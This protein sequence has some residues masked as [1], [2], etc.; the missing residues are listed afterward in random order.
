MAHKSGRELRK[1]S[2]RALGD[3]GSVR[4]H[5]LF[6]KEAVAARVVDVSPGGMGVM[7]REFLPTRL[8]RVGDPVDIVHRKGTREEA[9]V[10]AFVRNTNFSHLGDVVV[11]RIGLSFGACGWGDE[12]AAPRE[13][14]G[15]PYPNSGQADAT[16]LAELQRA[17]RADLEAAEALAA[18]AAAAAEPLRCPAFFLPT[19]FAE[20]PFFFQERIHFQVTGF[21]PRGLRLVCSARNKALVPG[22]SLRMTV[23][24]PL[25]GTFVARARPG[26]ARKLAQEDRYEVDAV[27]V[28]DGDAQ[29]VMLGVARYLLASGAAPSVDALEERGFPVS[30]LERFLQFQIAQTPEEKE[31]V[32][33]YWRGLQEDPRGRLV[34]CRLGADILGAGQ[35]AFVKGNGPRSVIESRVA[36]LATEVRAEGYVE[37]SWHCGSRNRHIPDAF[38]HFVKNFARLTLEAG[39]RRMITTCR[40]ET[41]PV[42]LALG[43]EHLQAESLPEWPDKEGTHVLS[44]DVA[45]VVQGRKRI[46]RHIWTKVYE[47]VAVHVG[48]LGIPFGDGGPRG[49][50]KAS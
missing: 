24:L 18:A 50:K 15:E 26:V 16:P 35:I 48:L 37:V 6:G 47:P 29:T 49:K 43:F 40:K 27:L 46:S 7:T 42:F 10:P 19:A 23:F 21:T 38:L 34:L 32:R 9:H 8:P 36:R 11:V 20:D 33:G 1:D 45:A 31:R 3:A 4:V 30:D 13:L 39:A 41:L 25:V 28:D 5:L 12:S 17:L 44:L 14:T 2:R 22:V